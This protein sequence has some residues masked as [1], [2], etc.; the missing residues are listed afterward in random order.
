M[1]QYLLVILV[2]LLHFLMASFP[3]QI[4]FQLYADSAS[5]STAITIKFS[6][7]VLRRI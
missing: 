3:R 2:L 5:T 6:A 7:N 1:T 4:Q